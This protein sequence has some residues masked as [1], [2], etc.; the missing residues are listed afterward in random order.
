M[1][2]RI[3]HC[4]KCSLCCQSFTV[5]ASETNS[6]KEASEKFGLKLIPNGDGTYRCNML[7]IETKQC[8]IYNNRPQACKDFP[9]GPLPWPC[10][11]RFIENGKKP[12]IDKET[13]LNIFKE[14]NIE[15]KPTA[16]DNWMDE[17]GEEIRNYGRKELERKRKLRH[18]ENRKRRNESRN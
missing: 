16:F 18:K 8:K 1:L 2:T 10:G 12:I 14:I 3:G 9:S 11:Y 4:L 15:I 5:V 13:L 7:D 17:R 6:F